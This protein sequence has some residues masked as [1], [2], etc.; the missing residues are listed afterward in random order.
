M[1]QHSTGDAS[2]GDGATPLMRA[3][4]VTDVELMKALL[5][6]GANPN[7][8]L[9]NGTTVL[10]NIAA[11]AGRPAP[12]EQTTIDVMAMLI[13]HGADVRVANGTGQTPLHLAIGRGDGIVTY[14][15]EHGAPLDAKDS[16]GRTPLDV[17]MGVQGTAAAGRGGR[18][19]RGG[20]GGPAGPPQVFESTAALLKALVTSQVPTNK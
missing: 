16:S 7:L 19:G 3:A 10:M 6:H 17:A 15:A 14:L 20:P 12:S 1:R 5:E 9:R 4:K 2:L 18:G 11:R 8:A 13:K